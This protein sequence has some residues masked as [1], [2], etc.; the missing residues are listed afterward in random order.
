MI[1][2][3]MTDTINR[4]ILNS[5]TMAK[6]LPLPTARAR[7]GMHGFR[8]VSLHFLLWSA[9]LVLGFAVV[10]IPLMLRGE[11]Q[12]AAIMPQEPCTMWPQ[13]RARSLPRWPVATWGARWPWDCTTR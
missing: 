3:S 12:T 7:H 2:H 1:T 13:A 4:A 11:Q 10:R 6:L 9:L 8:T 5:I